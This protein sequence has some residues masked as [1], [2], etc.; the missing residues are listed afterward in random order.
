LQLGGE[1]GALCVPASPGRAVAIGEVLS[2]DEPASAVIESVSLVNPVNIELAHIYVLPT[3]DGASIGT[4]YPDTDPPAVWDTK[5]EAIGAQIEGANTN[6][7]VVVS[8]PDSGVST[9]DNIRVKYR[10]D[11]TFFEANG[12][13]EYKLDDACE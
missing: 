3:V 9:A 11:G 7:V 6:L 10:L 1:A 4:M 5:E 8:R 2:L 12:S 13:I